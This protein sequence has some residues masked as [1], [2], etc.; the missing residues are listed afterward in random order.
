MSKVNAEVIE[1][2]DLAKY[3]RLNRKV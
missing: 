3:Y 1:C 2:C